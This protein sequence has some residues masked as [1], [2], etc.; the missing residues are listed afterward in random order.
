MR[1]LIGSHLAFWGPCNYNCHYCSPEG[2]RF[3]EPYLH[4]VLEL[5]KIYVTLQQHAEIVITY[6]H[7]KGSEPTIHPQISEVLEI[8]IS[9]GYVKLLTNM[10]IPVRKWALSDPSKVYLIA[11]LHP[12]AERDLDGFLRRLIEAREAGFY[13]VA[14]TVASPAKFSVV[15][16]LRKR[17]CEHGFQLRFSKFEGQHSGKVY[18]G[19]YSKREADAFWPVEQGLQPL[20]KVKPGMSPDGLCAA[21]WDS[22]YIWPQTLLAR[23]RR[24]YKHEFLTEPYPSPRPCEARSCS[25]REIPNEHNASDRICK[26][27]VEHAKHAKR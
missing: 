17:F 21:G 14:Q 25:N 24:D 19:A 22:V 2:V 3:P 27:M 20:L 5:R 4:D 11:T 7:A 23:C 9:A 26:T 12:P 13:I 15:E 18:P 10:S 6:M 16:E 8:A 1:K